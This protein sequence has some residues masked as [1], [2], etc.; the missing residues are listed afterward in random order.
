M[1]VT[2]TPDW[3]H[4]LVPRARQRGTTPEAVVLDAIREKLGLES[5]KSDEGP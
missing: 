1:K 2:L 3:E 4:A 5:A